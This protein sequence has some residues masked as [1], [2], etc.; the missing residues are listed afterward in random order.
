[1][2]LQVL[3][4][5]DEPLARARLRRLLADCRQPDAVAAGEAGTAAHAMTLVRNQSFDAVL[6]DVQ[7]PGADG[8]ALAATWRELEV[9]PPVVFVTAH[10]EYAVQAFEVDAIDYLTKP[11]R[12]QRLQKALQ[13]IARRQPTPVAADATQPFLTVTAQGRTERVPLADV[14]FFKAEDKYV[15]A[16]TGGDEYL[17]DTSLV[18]LERAHAARFLRI[19]RN[20]LVARNAIRA[21]VREREGPDAEGWVVELAGTETTLAVSRRQLPQIRAILAGQAPAARKV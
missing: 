12:L 3:I 5:D 10:P 19:H 9:S 4:V 13:K 8:M 16:C 15:M 1:M 7:M 18:Q 2:T 21:L 20:A 11:V 17:L 14:L 6:L